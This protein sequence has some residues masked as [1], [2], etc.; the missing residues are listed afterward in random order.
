LRPFG[1]QAFAER[2]GGPALADV[3]LEC[4]PDCVKLLDAQGRLLFFN[5]N[6]LSKMEI[7]NFA[8]IRGTYWP[9]MWPAH[10]RA[11]LERALSDANETGTGSFIADCPTAKGTPKWWDVVITQIPGEGREEKFVVISRDITLQR[12]AEQLERQNHERL[13]FILGSTT[14][15]LWEIDLASGKVWWSEGLSALFGYGPDQIG[16]NTEWCH[17][18]IHPEDRERVVGSM[19]AAVQNGDATWE[20]E[21]RYRKADG[22]YLDVYDRG[23]IVRDAAGKAVRFSGVMQ[24][25]SARK[26]SAT[27]QDSLARELAHRLNN[28]L[29]VV[30]G[31]FQQTRTMSADIETLAETFNNRIHAMANANSLLVRSKEGGA[32]LQELATLQLAPFRGGQRLQIDG[33]KIALGLDVSQAIAL[34]INEL[35]TNAMKYGALAVPEGRVSLTWTVQKEDNDDTLTIAWQERNGPLVSTPNRFGLGGKLIDRGIPGAR[36]ERT[37]AAEG[38]RCTIELLLGR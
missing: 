15:V 12:E 31:I 38:L 23:S 28:T 16:E 36:V 9:E 37:F 7:D 8:T 33:P 14:D 3:L 24:D 35:A 20:G 34:A 26:A 13:R 18:H 10:N 25:F 11:T 22:A 4:S 6:G 5:E 19:T 30:A 27:R 29:A 17:E 32:D 1:K 2:R 21:F